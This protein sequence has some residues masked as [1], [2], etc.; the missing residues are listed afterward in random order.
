MK[1]FNPLAGTLRRNPEYPR[2]ASPT[3]RLHNQDF[4]THVLNQG[5]KKSA[6]P[7]GYDMKIPNKVCA[8]NHL[9]LLTTTGGGRTLLNQHKLTA[10]IIRLFILTALRPFCGL[11]EKR[12]IA[13][14]GEVTKG[15][16]EATARALR[17]GLRLIDLGLDVAWDFLMGTAMV[18]W[19]VA[20]RRRS[21]LGLGWAIA[22]ALFGASAI[23]LNAATFP[24]PPGDRGLFDIG[25]FAALFLVGLAVR[26]VTLGRRTTS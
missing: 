12:S 3:G 20:M 15:L 4:R 24:W 16:D 19:G 21:G 13:G 22:A 23:V 2:A 8:E 10:G 6:Q 7:C 1:C 18:F 11:D 25:P 17:R 14:I 9:N 5:G 26:L